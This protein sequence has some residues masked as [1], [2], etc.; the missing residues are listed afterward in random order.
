MQPPAL[1]PVRSSP[2][3]YLL[4]F[5]A[6]VVGVAGL[7]AAAVLVVPLLLATVLALLCA[8]ALQAMQARRV[9]TGLGVGVIVIGLVGIGVIVASVVTASLNEF[10]GRL[11]VYRASLQTE[12]A[13]AVEWAQAQGLPIDRET[14]LDTLDPAAIMTYSA[15]LIGAV[16]QLLGRSFL[17]VLV[18]VFILLELGGLPSKLRAAS[19]DPDRSFRYARRFIGLVKH[20]LVIKTAVSA[21]TGLF[22]GVGLTLIGVD[23]APLWGLLAFLLNFIPTIGSLVAAVPAM[24]MAYI[25][26]G[27]GLALATGF[28]FGVVNVVLGNFLE[29]RI[30][31]RRVGLS[32][33]VVVLSLLVWGYVFGPVGMLLAV[34]LTMV[35]KLAME[36]NPEL[37]W[38]SVLLGPERAVGRERPAPPSFSAAERPEPITEEIA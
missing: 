19:D 34:P 26:G 25:E 5:A 32:P 28:V 30:L 36:A 20:Y 11:P 8:P 37:E 18:T 27:P 24:L 7:R 16:S 10:V 23:F 33:L 29:P 3:R 38:I 22:V 6:F 35:V 13:Q 9:P 14:A 15:G 4:G 17:I 12:L 1:R 2:L 21:A 31:G